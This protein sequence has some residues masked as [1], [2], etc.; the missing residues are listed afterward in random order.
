MAFWHCVADWA[1]SLSECSHHKLS[2]AP[3]TRAAMGLLVSPSSSS[4][5]FLLN[6][7]SWGVYA[8]DSCT[9]HTVAQLHFPH[10]DFSSDMVPPCCYWCFPVLI[11]LGCLEYCPCSAPATRMCTA[12]CH[13]NTGG[14]PSSAQD[15]CRW[16]ASHITHCVHVA[17]PIGSSS[18]K[19]FKLHHI[20][21]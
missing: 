2:E 9:S 14:W 10:R 7:L 4:L 17:Q 12:N 18:R 11:V 6:L 15:F 19:L 13:D 8:S 16:K 3:C 20:N 21:F 1:A 5:L